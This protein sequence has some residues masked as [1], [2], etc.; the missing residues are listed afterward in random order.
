MG[1]ARPVLKVF[2]LSC[3]Q[4]YHTKTPLDSNSSHTKKGI[5]HH[6]PS[7]SGNSDI[8]VVLMEVLKTHLIF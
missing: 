3:I 8:S 2:E 5:I 7:N 4:S 1:C 6:D